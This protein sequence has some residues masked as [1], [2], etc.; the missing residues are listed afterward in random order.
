[1]KNNIKALAFL[2]SLIFAGAAQA[3]VGTIAVGLGQMT[4]EVGEISTPFSADATLETEEMTANAKV[5]YQPGMVRDELNMG[6]Q[7][8]VTIN[9]FDLNKVWM[10]MMQSMYMEVDPEQGSDQAPQYELVSREI[11]GR[12]TVNG[13]DT[14]KYKSVYKTK[15]GRFGGFTWYT[16]DNIAVKAFMVSETNGDKQRVK[17]EFSN[18]QRGPQD[19]S[20]FELPPGA[21]KMNMGGLSGMSGM[22]NQQQRQ[23]MQQNQ[24][25]TGTAA[26]QPQSAEEQEPGF[27]E[28][29]AE[30]STEEAKQSAS[31]E[32]ANEIGSGVRKGI[33]RMFGR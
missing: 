3:F 4:D 9:R 31:D 8:I 26:P 18:L 7:Q 17:Y 32:I 14:T 29:V 28:E 20:L 12:E 24:P 11:I 25:N 21:Q 19:P 13:M 6:G 33:G 16:D 22:M 15:D 23:A 1:M 5:Y 27:V 10:I 2:L 30:K